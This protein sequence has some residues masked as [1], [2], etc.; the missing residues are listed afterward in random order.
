MVLPGIQAL[1]GFQLVAVFNSAFEQ[2]LSVAAIA[3][4]GNRPRCNSRRDH[5]DAG[6]VCTSKRSLR[7]DR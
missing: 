1:F 6:S 7:R 3:S 2:K 4:V 5:H